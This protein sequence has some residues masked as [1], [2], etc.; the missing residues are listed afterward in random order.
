VRV[1]LLALTS[2][3]LSAGFLYSGHNLQN[4]LLAVR[5]DSEGFS[6]AVIG[7]LMSAYFF[8]F[9]LGCRLAPRWI[10]AVGHIRAFTA[11]GSLAS[12]AALGHALILEPWF[13]LFARV[14]AGFCMAGVGM[15][16]E[17]W[18][19]ERAS[20]ADRGKLLSVYRLIELGAA[21]IGQALLTLA[22]PADFTLFA[23]T[24]ALV[25]IALVPVA[26]TRQQA[27]APIT[28]TDVRI[29][30]VFELSPMSAM[31][32][33]L[34][35]ASVTAFFGLGP[36]FAQRQGLG[37]EAVAVF[38]LS[39]IIGAGLLQWPLGVISDRIDR[40]KIVM[41]QSV[42]AGLAALALYVFAPLAQLPL[43][44]LV[45][46]FG[47]FAFTTFGICV[48]HA[49][50]YAE[51]TEYVSLNGGLL[52][53]YASGAMAGPLLGAWGVALLGEEGLFVIAAALHGALLLVAWQRLVGGVAA[54]DEL[55][56]DFSFATI[57][58]ANSPGTPESYELDPR[59]EAVEASNS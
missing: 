9:M 11:Y 38:M 16:I 44:L 1:K 31:G 20:N 28:A 3:F 37:E 5:G 42:V 32:S 43:L 46:V 25:S 45:A 34:A 33:M 14:A 48:A 58:A 47:G 8:G 53:L 2:L 29:K 54:P 7:A 36:L 26:L 57:G 50:D 17:S 12:V 51:P 35:G 19:N 13:W 22:S 52:M 24:S 41:M 30:R 55:R 21:M 15:I 40:R 23:L 56:E 18:L 39:A 49:N 4:T 6:V 27:P 10:A 59:A